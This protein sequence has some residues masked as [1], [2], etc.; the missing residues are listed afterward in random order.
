MEGRNGTSGTVGNRNDSITPVS[1]GTRS[2]ISSFHVSSRNME[3][4]VR[5]KVARF[6]GVH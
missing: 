2:T 5:N 1:N 6:Y 3:V 4:I